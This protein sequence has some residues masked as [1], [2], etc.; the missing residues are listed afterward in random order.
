MFRPLREKRGGLGGG[1]GRSVV[2]FGLEMG[3]PRGRTSVVSGE[4]K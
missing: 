3:A 2:S 1:S 4:G